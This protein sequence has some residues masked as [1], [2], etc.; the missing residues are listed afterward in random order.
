MLLAVQARNTGRVEKEDSFLTID[1]TCAPPSRVNT[2]TREYCSN[3]LI[4]VRVGGQ[5]SKAKV[6]TIGIMDRPRAAISGAGRY[7]GLCAAGCAR[8]YTNY[9]IS[10]EQGPQARLTMSSCVE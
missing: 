8:L 2:S 1:G 9:D 3:G 7:G 4:G 6:G 5:G 10:H